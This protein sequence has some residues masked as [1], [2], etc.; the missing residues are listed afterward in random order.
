MD[1]SHLIVSVEEGE[2]KRLFRYRICTEIHSLTSLDKDEEARENAIEQTIESFRKLIVSDDQLEETVGGSDAASGN[3]P[4]TKVVDEDNPLHEKSEQDV[5]LKKRSNVADFDHSTQSSDVSSMPTLSGS[6]GTPST[7][8]WAKHARGDA[9]RRLLAE[10]KTVPPSPIDE[11]SPFFKRLKNLDVALKR[12][13]ERLNNPTH[14]QRYPAGLYRQCW[15]TSSLAKSTVG[16]LLVKKDR[17]QEKAELE[18]REPFLGPAMGRVLIADDILQRPVEKNNRDWSW[19]LY[20][21]LREFPISQ[22]LKDEFSWEMRDR[23][24]YPLGSGVVQWCLSTI[25]L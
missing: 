6:A 16:E 22:H 18:K 24:I 21:A 19:Q 15:L 17:W 1:S 4:L 5:Q 2:D 13:H 7:P 23:E 9:L 11:T 10:R 8:F 14:M 20:K 25:G 12:V 3:A